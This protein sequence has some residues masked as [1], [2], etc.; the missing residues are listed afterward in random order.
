MLAMARL[1]WQPELERHYHRIDDLRNHPAMA[2][3]V[4][5]V[6][7]KPDDFYERT[8]KSQRLKKR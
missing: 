7:R 1:P 6:G 5:W 2:R 4:E 3:F 8:R